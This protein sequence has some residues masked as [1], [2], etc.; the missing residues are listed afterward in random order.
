MYKAY[1]RAPYNGGYP[2]V[3]ETYDPYGNP[4]RVIVQNP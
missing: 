3:V 4:Q 1:Q 2:Q